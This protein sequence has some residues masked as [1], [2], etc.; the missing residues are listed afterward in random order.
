MVPKEISEK[1]VKMSVCIGSSRAGGLCDGVSHQN[2]II[3]SKI[4]LGG[5]K[6]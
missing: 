1:E 5:M 2:S 6:R 4:Y 3:N